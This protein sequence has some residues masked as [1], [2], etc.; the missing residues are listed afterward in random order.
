MKKKKKSVEG[1]LLRRFQFCTC[2]LINFVSSPRVTGLA[3]G[4]A[5]SLRS[6][7]LLSLLC[8]PVG[9]FLTLL[10]TFPLGSFREF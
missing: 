1:F 2:V 6:R 8:L 3:A 7:G 10:Y 9:P 5:A 4:S